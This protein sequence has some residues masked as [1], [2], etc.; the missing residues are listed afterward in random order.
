MMKN[1]SKIN[2]SDL[3]DFFNYTFLASCF[4]FIVTFFGRFFFSHE[5]VDYRN[6]VDGYY[7]FVSSWGVSGDCFSISD[8]VPPGR[9][10]LIGRDVGDNWVSCKGRYLSGG[11]SHDV[12]HGSECKFHYGIL[13]PVR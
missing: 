4:I 6:E 3:G 10:Y 13:A 8:A 2:P 11:V 5:V 9:M 12:K 7:E 1:N